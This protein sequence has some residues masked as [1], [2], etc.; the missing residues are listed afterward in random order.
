MIPVFVTKY[1]N[2]YLDFMTKNQNIYLDFV[3][4]KI[5]IIFAKIITDNVSKKIS[6]RSSQMEK[7]KW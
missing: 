1:N 7:L 4:F 3:F 5:N 2:F 6:R